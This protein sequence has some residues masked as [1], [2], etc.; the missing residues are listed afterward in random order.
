[1]SADQHCFAPCPRGLEQVLA[2]ELTSLGAQVDGVRPG[3][4]AFRTSIEGVLRT[5]LWSRFASRIL[6]RLLQ[7]PYRNEQDIYKLA[8]GIDWP[9]WFDVGQTIK[10]ETNGIR[11]P[12]KSLEFVSLKVKD[13]VCDVFRD[14]CG[15]RPSVNTQRPDQRIHVF[16]DDTTATLY[17]DTSG[18]ALFKRGYRR[19]AGEAPLRENLA[20]GILRLAGWTPE[21]PLFDP[22]CG[23]G[24]FLTE[25]AMMAM[26]RAPGLG[27]EF[28]F[29][30]FAGI[31]HAQWH[32]L[33]DAATARITPL[34][35][36]LIS[37]RDEDAEV[38]GHAR[39]H[40]AALG[41]APQ[42]VLAEGDALSA[43]APAPS[44]VMVMN[45]PYGE[46]MGEVTALAA[47]YP[48]L[49]DWLKQR[50]AGW[51]AWIL[52]GDLQGIRSIGLAP[53]RKV[54]LFNGPIECRLL[55]YEM[56][57]GARRRPATAADSHSQLRD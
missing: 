28:A 35:D 46:R 26:G 14:A 17:L 39:R 54:P 41:C 10:V 16:L 20:A 19:G 1:M 30:R 12:V 45:P 36:G 57:A 11:A 25:A 40:L 53:S 15:E 44:G 55:R 29:E 6:L 23:S 7:R 21:R 24:T 8:R 18:E 42:V 50:F 31:D 3:G 13:A 56:V 9:A 4:V 37:G 43:E 22:M 49:G 34:P 48:K 33:R 51:D 32:A 38:L 27:R 47:W 52:T 5:N 2:D